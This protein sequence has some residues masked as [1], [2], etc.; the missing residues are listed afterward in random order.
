M[1]NFIKLPKLSRGDQVAVIS[2]SNGLPGLFPWVQDLGYERLKNEFDLTPKEYPTTRQMGAPL[3]DRARD[4]MAAFADKNNKAV[5]ASIGGEDQIQLIKYLKD[6]IF[7]QNPKPFFG[8]S[9]NT[10]LHNYLWSQGIRSYYG[11]DVMT[12]FAFQGKM[13]DLTKKFIGHALFDEGEIEL[14][15]SDKFND[16]GLDWADKSNLNKLRQFEPNQGLIWDGNQNAEGVLWGGCV[17]S[18]IVQATTNLYLPKDTDLDN[19]ILYLETAEDIPEHWV[20]EYLLIGYGEKGWLDKFSAILVGRP[21]AWEFNKQNDANQKAQYKKEQI[22]S[23]LK[24]VRQYNKN[25][26]VI[27]NLDFGHTSPQIILPSGNRARIDS[28]NHK[29]Y[30]TY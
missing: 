2:P 16:I 12:N 24:I 25:I 18:L 1:K 5:F 17:E 23:V 4:I 10:H 20:I 6:E 9:D 19:T 30:L 21:K 28:Q 27:Q 3:E 7:L 26:P 11:G 29:I 13:V 14:Q 22:E 15:V 8:S